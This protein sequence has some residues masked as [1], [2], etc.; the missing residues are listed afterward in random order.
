M[1]IFITRSLPT[2][3]RGVVLLVAL[4]FLV[5]LSLLGVGASRMVASEERMSRYLREYN[6]AFQ[7]GEAALRDA[8]DDIDG[9]LAPD[10][11]G[12]ARKKA[13][14]R[15]DGATDFLPNCIVG[16]CYYNDSVRPW[17]EKTKWA[18]AVEYGRYSARSPLPSS[19]IV[20][21]AAG[22]AKDENESTIDRY[23]NTTSGSKVTGVWQQPVYLIEAVPDSR[24][25]TAGLQTGLKNQE[26]IY[27]ITARGFGADPASQAMVQ[28]LYVS[29]VRTI[30]TQQ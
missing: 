23:N 12:V 11:S 29:E 27:R 10:S 21:K 19:N 4:L 14:P 1:S 28:E 24:P 6:T 30:A 22:D 26:V 16:L 7:A 13:R 5:V 2:K 20:G 15:I 3:Q 18:N 9:Y 17:T 25:G 8:R